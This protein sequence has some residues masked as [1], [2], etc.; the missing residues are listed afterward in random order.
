MNIKEAIQQKKDEILVLQQELE[1]LEKA[2]E[3]I[4]DKEKETV[5]LKGGRGG[6]SWGT[7]QDKTA[8]KEAPVE[9]D[10]DTEIKDAL[11]KFSQL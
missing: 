2:Q 4:S 10:E 5:L 9:K 11:R 6:V 3:I 7:V 1:I 8:I